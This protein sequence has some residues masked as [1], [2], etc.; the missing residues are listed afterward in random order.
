VARGELSVGDALGDKLKDVQN[1]LT[2]MG[3]FWGTDQKFGQPFGAQYKPAQ[4][5]IF[6]LVSMI[7]SGLDG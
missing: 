3:T 4:D 6:Q 2:S 1:Q 7:V 5:K